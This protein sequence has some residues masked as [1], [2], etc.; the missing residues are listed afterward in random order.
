MTFRRTLPPLLTL[1]FAIMV[2]GQKR[3]NSPEPGPPH[4]SD[5]LRVDVDLVL[6]PVTVT[7]SHGRYVKGLRKENF[8]LWEDKVQQDVEYFSAENIPASVGIVLDVSGSMKDKLSAARSA[9][10]TFMKMGGRQDEYFLITF[11]NDAEFT[12]G[13]TTDIARLQDRIAFTHANGMTALYDAVYLGLDRVNQGNNTRKALL[14]ITD[15]DDNHSRYS[16]SNVKEFAKERD[17][18]IYAIGILDPISTQYGA[19]TSG[20]AAL[21]DLSQVTGGRAFFPDSAFELEDICTLIGFDLKNQYVLGYRS[22]NP[23]GNG[24]W[25]KINVKMDRQDG[26]PRM[27]V[28]AKSGYYAPAVMKALK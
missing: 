5:T 19:A 22:S 10:V 11:G 2:F 27:N 13:F 12:S 7:D 16:Y 15:G 14:L 21:R 18:Q 3:G 17:V 24:K 9:A 6:V 28:R 26:M 25:R 4:V 23:E 1:V 8:K 20:R